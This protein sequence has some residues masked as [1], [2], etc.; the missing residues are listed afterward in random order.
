VKELAGNTSPV[1]SGLDTR[2]GGAAAA[3]LCGV[4]FVDVLGVTV[5]ITALPRMLDDLAATPTQGT[6][7]VTAY[8]LFFGGLLMVASRVG[9]RVGHR[10]AVL[11][12]LALIAVASA[13]GG[14]AQ[15]VWVLAIARALQGIAAAAS[16]PSA[17]R[18]LTTVVPDGPARRRA[19]A[20]WSAAGAAAGASGFVV[21]GVF[22]E[23]ASWR[24]VFWMNVALAG[25]LAG[26][27]V[28]L[29]ARDQPQTAGARIGGPS[30]ISLTA[31]AMGIV[32]GTTLLGEQTP[33]VL[34]GAVTAVGV[35]AA[36][37]FVLVERRATHPLVAPAA[38]R[39]PL[40]RWAAFGS[41]FN[42]ATTSSSITVAT[43]YLQ[44]ELGLT[45]LATAALLVTFS[46]LVWSAHS[47]L[48]DSSHRAAGAAPSAAA[49]A[50]SRAATPCSSPGRT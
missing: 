6:A 17:L 36:A 25:L 16:V 19:V 1:R 48:Q 41:F 39:S 22:T 9:D 44:D 40:L 28:W 47:V 8:A 14:L 38:R 12:A 32:A 35:L 50:S 20:G 7:V 13:L 45:P 10:R 18:L 46:I 23:L 11:A 5:V 29:I 27:I 4:Q 15:S 42:T 21:G 34:A 43:L 37:G 49:S 26:A 24:T 3:A 2:F 30:A 31:G 33:T